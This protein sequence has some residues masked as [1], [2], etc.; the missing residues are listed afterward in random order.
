MW[1]QETGGVI[2]PIHK[3]GSM[4]LCKN[5]RGISLLSVPGEVFASILNN[6]AQTVTVDKVTE[7]QAR[8]R[9]SRGCAE[10]IFVIRQLAEKMIEKGKKL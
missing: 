2:V 7:E 10:Q 8:F 6:R 1:S 5:N 3:K 9:R 4:K